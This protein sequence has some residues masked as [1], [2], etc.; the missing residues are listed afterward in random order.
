M[1]LT[2]PISGL[3]AIPKLPLDIFYLHTKFGDSS[4][5]PFRRYD[6]GR[7]NWK[8]VMWPCPHSF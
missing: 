5:S 4:F 8:W 1:T 2:T 3:S 6:C 7:R